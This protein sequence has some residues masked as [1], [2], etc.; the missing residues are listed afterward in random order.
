MTTAGKKLGKVLEIPRTLHRDVIWRGLCA[1]FH[2]DYPGIRWPLDHLFFTR[3]F[4]LADMQ[5]LE[6]VGSDLFP[7]LAKVCLTAV[8]PATASTN[9]TKMT[10]RADAKLTKAEAENVN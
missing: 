4:A 3:D 8:A 6:L 10:A 1:S 7:V 2:A 5:V 9:V